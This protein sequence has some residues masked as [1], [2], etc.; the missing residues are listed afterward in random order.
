LIGYFPFGRCA[1][2]SSQESLVNF[3]VGGYQSGPTWP[4]VF[5]GVVNPRA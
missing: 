3:K 2:L 1:V 4:T 5:Y